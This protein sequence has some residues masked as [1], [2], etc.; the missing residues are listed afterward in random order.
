MMPHFEQQF[1][2]VTFNGRLEV[3]HQ[4]RIKFSLYRKR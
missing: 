2:V 1:F 3:Y 4:F